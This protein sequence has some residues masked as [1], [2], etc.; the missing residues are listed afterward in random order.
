MTRYGRTDAEWQSLTDAGLGFLIDRARL[1]KVTSYTELNTV[2]ANRT[3]VR[4]FDFDRADERAAMG[5]LLGAIVD[6]NR[7]QTGLMISALV[8]YLNENDA[9]AGFYSFAQEL[10]LLSKTASADERL[11]FWVGQVDGLHQF[12][13]Q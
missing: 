9:G 12:Y 13:A 3:G 4:P 2:L 7:P 10:G 11:S 1:G 5:E 8:H 6:R